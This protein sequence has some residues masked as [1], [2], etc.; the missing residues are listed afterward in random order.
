MKI[1]RYNNIYENIQYKIGY[2]DEL[3]ED[4]TIYDII[5]PDYGILYYTNDNFQ[6]WLQFEDD[7]IAIYFCNNS[8]DVYYLFDL[9]DTRLIKYNEK[10]FDS[11]VI[12]FK[13]IFKKYKEI[14][15]SNPNNIKKIIEKKLNAKKFNL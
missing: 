10:A 11:H 14:K 13:D 6:I 9:L 15:S 8:G 4:E 7:D 3:D 5:H 1:K 12:S 2:I